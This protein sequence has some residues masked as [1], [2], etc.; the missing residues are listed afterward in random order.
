[1]VSHINNTKQSEKLMED[2]AN[3]LKLY[4]EQLKHLSHIEKTDDLALVFITFATL[5]IFVLFHIPFVKEEPHDV[6]GLGVIAIILLGGAG[7]YGTT[8]RM[9]YRM[10]HVVIINRVGRALGA[11]QAGIIPASLGNETAGNLWDFGKRLFLGYRGPIIVFYSTAIWALVFSLFFEIDFGTKSLPLAA[12]TGLAIVAVA[13][14]TSILSSWQQLKPEML[15]L[16]QEVE[17]GTS[18]TKPLSEQHCDLAD[19]MMRLR[20]PR[21]NEALS[22]YEEALILEPASSRAKAGFDKLMSWKI[23]DYPYKSQ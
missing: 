12:L 20:P 7:I 3:L 17:L 9:T 5:A 4:Q 2:P 8:R 1:M 11:V 10:Q 23:R 13:N 6:I 21:L 18:T 15:A 16:K 22:Y 14:L 19:S